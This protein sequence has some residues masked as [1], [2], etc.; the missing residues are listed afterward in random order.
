MWILWYRWIGDTFLFQSQKCLR[1]NMD[2]VSP[3]LTADGAEVFVRWQTPVVRWQNLSSRPGYV[4]IHWHTVTSWSQHITLFTNIS[5]FNTVFSLVSAHLLFM[6]FP[7]SRK[8][9][10]K[11]CTVAS[12]ALLLHQQTRRCRQILIWITCLANAGIPMRLAGTRALMWTVVP[13]GTVVFGGTKISLK[14]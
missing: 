14:S 8:E 11:F 3:F 10:P 13:G 9:N 1:N 6:F 2:E 5:I 7:K 4:R 12:T